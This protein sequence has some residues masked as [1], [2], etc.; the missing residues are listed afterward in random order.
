MLLK[1]TA[2]MEFRPAERAPRAKASQFYQ[3][4]K[5]YWIES[6]DVFSAEPFIDYFSKSPQFMHLN[7][8][9]TLEG[10]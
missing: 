7:I 8:K 6:A 3:Q 1:K 4:V 10:S 9:L 5:H 2:R